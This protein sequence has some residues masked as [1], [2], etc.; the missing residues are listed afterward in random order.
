MSD[1]NVGLPFKK[2]VE[3]FVWV[4]V[5][6]YKDILLTQTLKKM[7][8]SKF[9]C[10]FVLSLFLQN[11]SVVESF[12]LTTT[13]T[14]FRSVEQLSTAAFF[15]PF[16]PI[17]VSLQ[18]KQ[19]Y[20]K[21][22]FQLH[23]QNSNENVEK[24]EGIDVSSHPKLYKIRLPRAPG[25]EWGTDLSFSFV[26][27]RDLEPSGPARLSGLVSKGDQICQLQ[28]VFLDN[29]D[30]SKSYPP[31]N[32]VGTSFDTVMNS[33]ATLE[34]NIQVVD[35]VFF[36]GTKEELIAAAKENSSSDG[37]SD[38]DDDTITITVVENKDSSNE[39][40][41][42]FQAKQGCNV[43]NELINR[44]INVYQSIT[45]FTNCKGKQLCGTCIVNM[46]EG[47][48]FT[49]RK[50]MDEESTLRENPD[51]YR[52]ACVTFAYGDITVETY[53]PVNKAQWTR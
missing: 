3:V 24:D 49:N 25:I 27:V 41:T 32:L 5:S 6:K 14:L 33:F 36:K 50:S 18:Q 21:F 42:T 45:R 31:I 16:N 51:S 40:I 4:G 12:M 39:K 22:K 1:K 15:S 52:L 7:V 20:P 28:P 35:L 29:D 11:E 47:G 13:K 23:S 46:K 53:P 44:G 37:N 2:P 17:I 30:E 38:T 19:Q 8:S 34:K 9:S 48:M 10:L 26:Y 43:R